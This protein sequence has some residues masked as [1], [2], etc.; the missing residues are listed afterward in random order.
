MGLPCC[1]STA[2]SCL[3]CSRT[4]VASFP[5]ACSKW[6][7]SLSCH[8]GSPAFLL[9]PTQQLPSA[10]LPGSGAGAG[11]RSRRREWEPGDPYCHSRQNYGGSEPGPE[12]RG[13]TLTL[14][15]ALA[16]FSLPVGQPCTSLCHLFNTLVLQTLTNMNKCTVIGS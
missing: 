15:R 2:T 13:C 5:A 16:T 11:A 10:L 7:L 12:P 14:H 9:V 6:Q 4:C 3:L 1:A 8:V